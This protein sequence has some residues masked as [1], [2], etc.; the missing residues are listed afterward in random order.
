MTLAELMPALQSLPR[1]DKLRVIQLLVSD[2]T[3]QEG[4]E[5]MLQDGASYPIWTPLE[6]YGA[7]QTLHEL[8]EQDRRKP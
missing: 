3:R 6:A 1:D 7:A 2:L 4:V 5:L 8:L